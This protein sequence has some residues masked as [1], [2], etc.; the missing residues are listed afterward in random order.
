[1][2]YH[3]AVCIK[4]HFEDLMIKSGSTMEPRFLCLE[5][6]VFPNDMQNVLE[7]KTET[8]NRS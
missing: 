2:M 4:N 1:M 7:A 3:N 8:V 5:V 6:S